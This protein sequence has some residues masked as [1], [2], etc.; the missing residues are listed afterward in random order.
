MDVGH[1]GQSHILDTICD[2]KG[3]FAKI[4]PEIDW[5][6]PFKDLL[7]VLE[8]VSKRFEEHILCCLYK[9]EHSLA[10]NHPN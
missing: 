5:Q 4:N 1:E 8:V 9:K 3:T 2:Y 10:S 7:E 6:V